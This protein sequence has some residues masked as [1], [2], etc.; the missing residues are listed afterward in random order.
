LQLKLGGREG[1]Q[2]VKRGDDLIQI[3]PR[4]YQVALEQAQGALERDRAYRRSG[5]D[6]ARIPYTCF[7]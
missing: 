5:V 7:I 6:G 2:I 4:P 3:D 1:R